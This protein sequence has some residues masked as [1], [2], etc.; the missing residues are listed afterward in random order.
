MDWSKLHTL[1]LNKASSTVLQSLKGTILPKLKHLGLTGGNSKDISAYKDFVAKTV[2]PLE[3]LSLK[4]ISLEDFDSFIDIITQRHGES[5][6]HLNLTGYKKPEKSHLFL[7]TTSL[8]QFRLSC[9]NLEILEIGMP[10]TL[11]W[12]YP[13]LV[14]LA[15]FPNLRHLT[16]RLK[17]QNLKNA[18]SNPLDAQT[19]PLDTGYYRSSPRGENLLIGRTS[20]HGLFRYLRKRKIGLELKTLDLYVDMWPEE[21]DLYYVPDL[22]YSVVSYRCKVDEFGVERCREGWDVRQ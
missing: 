7:N 14:E 19:V 1:H 18:S 4:S 13:L 8:S 21:N 16:L 6:K 12:D 20:A 5:I 10:N 9:P 22:E 15:A 3:S 11:E 17:S 2:L